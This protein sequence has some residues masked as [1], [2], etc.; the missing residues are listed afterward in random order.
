MTRLAGAPSE[1]DGLLLARGWILRIGADKGR[2]VSG[3]QGRHP[4]KVTAGRPAVTVF[5]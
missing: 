1:N 3:L 2:G 5:R 4:L